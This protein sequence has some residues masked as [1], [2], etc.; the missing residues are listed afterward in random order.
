MCMW[1]LRIWIVYR[2]N[3]K[4]WKYFY[5]LIKG[6]VDSLKITEFEKKYKVNHTNIK[7]DL[8]K[9]Y[10]DYWKYKKILVIDEEK[11]FLKKIWGV[12]EEEQKS[13]GLTKRKIKALWY[14]IFFIL[15]TKTEK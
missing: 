12:L 4:Y 5:D 13:R 6:N 9:F 10:F 14:L 1:F 3:R 15:F 8:K 2:K 7:K 11:E